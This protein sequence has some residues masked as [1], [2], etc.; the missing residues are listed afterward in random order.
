MDINKNI[1][2]PIIVIIGIGLILAIYYQNGDTMSSEHAFTEIPPIDM[3]S[4]QETKTAAFALG[5]FW[6]VEAQF[7]CLPGVVYTRVG[8]TGGTTENPSYHNLG[9]HTETVQVVYDPSKI[10]YEELLTVFWSNRNAYTRSLSRQYMSAIF[11]YSDVQKTLTMESYHSMSQDKNVFV[12]IMEIETFYPAE[13]Y[14]QKY[15]LQQKSELMKEFQIYP[16]IED[17]IESTAATRL[18]GY[19]GGCGTITDLQKEID[20]YGLSEEGKDLLLRM[21]QERS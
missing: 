19:I 8:Y 21:V 14:H 1:I 13:D 9:D 5:C 18:N 15:F 12:E 17:F 4:P 7:G 20:Q 11:Y 2:I 6:G 3:V 10:S 16:N